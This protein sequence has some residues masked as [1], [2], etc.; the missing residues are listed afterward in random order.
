MNCIKTGAHVY[1]DP[2]DEWAYG[3]AFQLGDHTYFRLYAKD[4]KPIRPVKHFTV[5]MID[6]W[7]D[8]DK[9]SMEQNSTLIATAWRYHGYE[10]IAI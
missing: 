8:E 9:T 5:Y 3:D 1:L 7:W 2:Y 6:Q 10:G 4:F